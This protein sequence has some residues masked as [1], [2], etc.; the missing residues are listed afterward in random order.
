MRVLCVHSV[1]DDGP[2]PQ[3]ASEE[4]RGSGHCTGAG[5]P[6]ETQAVI[7]SAVRRGGGDKCQHET[8]GACREESRP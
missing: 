7:T 8:V 5:L 1:L 2:G 4:E 3:A 6:M